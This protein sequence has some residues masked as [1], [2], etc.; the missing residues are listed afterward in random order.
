MSGKSRLIL[1]VVAGVCLL[2][3]AVIAA[4][5]LGERH[6][7]PV[8]AGAKLAPET[9]NHLIARVPEVVTAR[10]PLNTEPT[11]VDAS[12]TTVNTEADPRLPVAEPLTAE[13]EKAIQS[14]VKAQEFAASFP[15]EGPAGLSKSTA[16]LAFIQTCVGH[17]LAKAHR[18]MDGGADTELSKMKVAADEVKFFHEGKMYIVRRGEFPVYDEARDRVASD[19]AS[20][21]SPEYYEEYQ[22]IF[23]RALSSLGVQ[24]ATK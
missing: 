4:R 12:T 8:D 15:S 23:A 19:R 10:Q 11:K 14:L 21:R 2:G 9:S 16:E 5:S 1:N 7:E 24:K 13:E 18:G 22:A 17:I 3:I 6:S 20:P